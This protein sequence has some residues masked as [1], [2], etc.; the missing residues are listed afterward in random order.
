MTVTGKR[1]LSKCARCHSIT[2]CGQECQRK[3]WPRHSQFCIPVMVTEIPGKGRGLVASKDIKKGQTLFEETA[4]IAVHAPSFMVPLKEMKEQISKMSVEQ[5][6]KFYQLKSKGSL[7]ALQFAAALRENCLPE[8]DIFASNCSQTRDKAEDQLELFLSTS[9]LNHSCA[10]NVV[11]DGF[12]N[13][14]LAH[15]VKVRAIK[16][17]SKGEE[18]TNCYTSGLMTRSQMKTKLKEDFSFD[19]KCAVCSGSI[20][21]QDILISEI[22]SIIDLL[23][24]YQPLDYLYQKRIKVWMTEASQ[25]ER[26]ADLA[27]QLYIGCG[28]ERLTV[29]LQFVLISQMARDPIR[30]QKAMDLFGGTVRAFGLMESHQGKAYQTLK[31]QVERWSSEFQSKKKP[32]KEEIDDFYTGYL[33]LSKC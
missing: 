2:Y 26:A 18:V 11:R 15:E 4:A 19:C 31:T 23:S 17:I 14:A 8:L 32:T 33:T 25:L 16:D 30:L 24:Y 10:P 28:S 13:S 27:K 5:K 3:D 22:S 12:T 9:L 6:S 29:F 20:P 7:N 21:H 1:K